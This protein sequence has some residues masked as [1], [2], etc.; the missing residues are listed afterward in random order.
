LIIP[1]CTASTRGSLVHGTI[2][3]T[4]TIAGH[5]WSDPWLGWI[6]DVNDT[7]TIVGADGCD[8]RQSAAAHLT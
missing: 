3:L 8:R 1:C 6:E 5:G 2:W 4:S 7:G